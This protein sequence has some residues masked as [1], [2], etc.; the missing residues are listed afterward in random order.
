MRERIQAEIARVCDT[1]RFILGADVET[2]ERRRQHLVVEL[3][4]CHGP[5]T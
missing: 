3:A 2:F 1:Q 4:R 5:T